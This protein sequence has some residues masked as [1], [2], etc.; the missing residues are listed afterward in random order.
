MSSA[1]S[2]RLAAVVNGFNTHAKQLA[3]DMARRFPE[4]ATVGRVQKRVK[5]VTET[6]PEF[7]I[8][9]AGE[10]LAVYADTIYSDD[11]DRWK[12]FFD[13]PEAFSDRVASA[14]TAE[15]REQASYLIPKI[16]ALAQGEA[17]EVRR[18]YIEKLRAMLELYEQFLE[19]RVE[20]H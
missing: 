5:A 7:V 11:E 10:Q 9:A 20:L 15:T 1:H 2:R 16:Q 6:L 13:D 17:A 14:K 8:E 3:M 4:D 18:H 12:V 19:A